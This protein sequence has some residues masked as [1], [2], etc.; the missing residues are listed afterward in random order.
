VAL[1][2]WI[3]VIGVVLF[4]LVA[5]AEI[6]DPKEWYSPRRGARAERIHL[7]YVEAVVY[8]LLIVNFLEFRRG[9]EGVVGIP[10]IGSWV[11]APVALISVFAVGVATWSDELNRWRWATVFVLWLAVIAGYI[12]VVALQRA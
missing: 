8:L 6:T 10:G 5:F 9:L 11:L 4:T 1:K 2:D 3:F 12:L 7:M